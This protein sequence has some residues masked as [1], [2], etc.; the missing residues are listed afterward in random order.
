V[1]AWSSACIAT[2]LLTG[3]GNDSN[4]D[5]GTDIGTG[6]GSTAGP[7]APSTG[8]DSPAADTSAGAG[9][10]TGTGTD[11]GDPTHAVETGSDESTGPTEP[12]LPASVWLPGLAP[13]RLMGPDLHPLPGGLEGPPI[14][15]SNNPEQF[16][17]NGWLFQH[18]RADAT[19][20]GESLPMAEFVAYVFNLNGTGGA[21]TLHLI[22]TNPQAETV[23]LSARGS[24]YVNDGAHPIGQGT[25]PSVQVARDWL[26]GAGNIEVQ[27]LE[28]A[29]SQGV[30]IGS[31][32]VQ[33]SGML[34]GRVQIE[35]SGGIYLYS[36]VTNSGNVND[37]INATQE[38]P[39]PGLIVEPGP[40]EFG[41]MA[42]VYSN[43]RWAS[44]VHADVPEGPAHVGVA[45]NTNDK[46]ALDGAT[47]HDQTAPASM[48]LAD[49][50]EK[51]Y[52]NYGMSYAVTL[53]LCS[54]APRTVRIGFA[55]N[56]TSEGDSPTFTWNGPIEVDGAVVDVYTRPTDPQQD[57]TTVSLPGGD[58]QDVALRLLV[59]GL[60]TAGQQ[61]ILESQ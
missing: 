2:S 59:P 32:G 35:A 61:I 12:D 51:S 42:G 45:F 13:A 30:Q 37:A 16:T 33:S 54:E 41:R 18:A 7:R 49:S 52:G 8:D 3:C 21:R 15:V 19:R 34:D 50:S 56:F 53:N 43:A 29:P 39:A 23:T 9:S 25:G 14:W 60:I 44:T 55:S 26:A 24:I 48:R 36:V 38:S 4:I 46:F 27:D 20:G 47:L 40:N 57:L 17:G 5:G 28:I 22:A 10:S 11:D 1:R 58:C 6:S 31:I